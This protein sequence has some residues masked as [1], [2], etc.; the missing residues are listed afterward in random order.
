MKKHLLVFSFY[1]LVIIASHSQSQWSSIDMPFMPKRDTNHIHILRTYTIDDTLTMER[2]LLSTEEYDRHGYPVSPDIQLT[3]NE[4]G[5]LVKYVRFE[6]HYDWEGHWRRDT[7]PTVV[8]LIQY[9]PEGIVWQ[10]KSTQYYDN[11]DSNS[12]N[13]YEL[14]TYKTHPQYGVLD[15]SYLHTGQFG[16]DHPDGPSTYQNTSYFRRQFDSLG[17][18]LHQDEVDDWTETHTSLHYHYHPN[19]RVAYRTGTYY[20]FEDSIVYQ[21]DTAGKLN[22]MIGK[23]YDL[24]EEGDVVIRCRP[25]GKWI[26]QITHWHPYGDIPYPYQQTQ[27]VLYDTHGMPVSDRLLGPEGHYIEYEIVYWK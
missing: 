16:F 14:I 15:C 19:G 6:H 13:T 5:Q 7:V 3:Y 23:Y 22:G 18:L 26:E 1:L 20:E 2:K 12:L 17:H 9:T 10:V 27:R 21:Y 24:E 11:G 8:S 25:D 4:K